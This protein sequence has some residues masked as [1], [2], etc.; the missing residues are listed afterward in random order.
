MKNA[1]GLVYA[2]CKALDKHSWNIEVL[3][4]AQPA[5]DSLDQLIIVSKTLIEDIRQTASFIQGFILELTQIWGFHSV[6]L[7]CQETLRCF[8]RD[9]RQQTQ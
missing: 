6:H 8:S 2:A 4:K 1:D 7:N 5:P 9:K 3:A